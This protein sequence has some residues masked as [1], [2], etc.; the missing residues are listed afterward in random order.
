M[1]DEE[2]GYIFTVSHVVVNL[3]HPFAK[4]TVESSE[5]RLVLQATPFAERKDVACKTRNKA[6]I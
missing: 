5:T 6:I 1:R 2:Q 4:W 3:V